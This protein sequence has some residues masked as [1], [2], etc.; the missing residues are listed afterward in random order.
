VTPE[1]FLAA[2]DEGTFR[3]TVEGR[4]VEFHPGHDGVLESDDG[5]VLVVDRTTPPI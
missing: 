2:Y 4:V 5:L 1:E 3:V